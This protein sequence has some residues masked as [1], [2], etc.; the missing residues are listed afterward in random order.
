MILFDLIILLVIPFTFVYSFKMKILY[1]ICLAL[2]AGFAAGK[3]ESGSIVSSGEPNTRLE[4]LLEAKGYET[5]CAFS[6]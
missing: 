3:D 6:A 4:E 5:V 2:S 1:F